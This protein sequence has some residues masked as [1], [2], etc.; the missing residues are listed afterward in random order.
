[1]LSFIEPD[2]FKDH[3]EISKFTFKFKLWFNSISKGSE[4]T[5]KEISFILFPFY[6]M[7]FATKKNICNVRKKSQ[8]VARDEYWSICIRCWLWFCGI[9]KISATHDKIRK[10]MQFHYKLCDRKC[11]VSSKSLFSHSISIFQNP[12]QI[13]VAKGS[14]LRPLYEKTP[15]FLNFRFYIFNITNKDDFIQGSKLKEVYLI[16]QFVNAIFQFSQF[17]S[18]FHCFMFKKRNQ[19]FKRL[20]RIF[21]SEHFEREI[22]QIKFHWNNLQIS[23]SGKRNLIWLTMKKRTPSSITIKTHLYF[24]RTW[25]LLV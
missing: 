10:W 19:N 23:E 22:F 8:H 20:D 4:E 12:Q 15:F 5:P 24:G 25:V 1:M 6:S 21:L 16:F 17:S 7:Q 18:R 9:S 13:N 11:S 2:G 3:T 14:D